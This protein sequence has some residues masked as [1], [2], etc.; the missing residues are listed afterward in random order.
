MA[1]RTDNTPDAATHRGSDPL[2]AE[3]GK[4]ATQDEIVADIEETR[5]QLR[6]TVDSLSSKLDVKTNA[7]ARV[8]KVKQSAATKVTDTKQSVLDSYRLLLET[9][10]VRQAR[11]KPAVPAGAALG[12][13]VVVV[14]VV[15]WRRRDTRP[16]PVKAVTKATNKRGM[17]SR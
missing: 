8:D 13:L 1:E 6:V 17:R 2:P 14:G 4:G 5:E 16:R 7:K 12:L 3:P 15:V 9:E 10:P 11:A